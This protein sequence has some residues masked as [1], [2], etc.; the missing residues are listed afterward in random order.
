VTAVE[1][2]R[3]VVVI[4]NGDPIGKHI[5]ARYRVGIIGLIKRFDTY[6]NAFGNL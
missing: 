1:L 5:F 2:N 4:F 3:K 6:F